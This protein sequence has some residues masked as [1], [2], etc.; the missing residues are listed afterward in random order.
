GS[1][2]ATTGRR[3]A[4]PDCPARRPRRGTPEGWPPP[5]H[6]Y[7]GDLSP[8]PLGDESNPI[9]Q[10]T[11]EPARRRPDVRS[12]RPAHRTGLALYPQASHSR[13]RLSMTAQSWFRRRF[14][15]SSP[16]SS[17]RGWSRRRLRPT[18]LALEGRELLSTLT[19]SNTNDSGAGSLRAAVLQAN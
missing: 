13:S 18:V 1:P 8:T 3:D 7:A 5:R 9:G 17:G 10:Q 15:S 16:A 2:G 6:R 14:T 11:P 4:R 12:A 19:V